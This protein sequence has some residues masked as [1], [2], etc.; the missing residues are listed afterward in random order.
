MGLYST[1]DV[2]LDLIYLNIGSKIDLKFSSLTAC[3]SFSYL[4]SPSLPALYSSALIMPFL[5]L[6]FC[7]NHIVR[8]L[9]K[10]G[11]LL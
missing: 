4:D 11:P 10:I 7:Q 2:L 1:V 6:T 5:L 3:Y 8:L 9:R